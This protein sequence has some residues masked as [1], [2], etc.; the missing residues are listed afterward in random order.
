M[1]ADISNL[2]ESNRN[3]KSYRREKGFC[4]QITAMTLDGAPLVVARIYWPADVAYCVAWVYGDDSHG[5]GCGRA[6]GGGYHKESAALDSALS[7]AGVVL[8]EPVHG[9]GHSAM[10]DAVEA[11]ARAIA[12]RR[13]IL[14]VEAHA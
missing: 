12:G 10:R 8:S 9:R 4:R 14:V 3:I 13:K 1:K 11:V 7:D 6:D 2:T 5:R